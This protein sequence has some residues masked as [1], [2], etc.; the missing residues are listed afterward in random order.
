MPPPIRRDPNRLPPHD[1]TAHPPAIQSA[2]PMD[3]RTL[4][5]LEAAL[6]ATPANAPLLRVVLSALVDRGEAGRAARLLS[7][8]SQAALD[9]PGDRVLVGRI[10]V[11][12]GDWDRALAVLGTDSPDELLLRARVLLALDQHDEGRKAY[13]RAVAANPALEDPDLR[14]RLAAR[15]RAFIS[16]QAGTQPLLRV[17]ERGDDD[18]ATWL[19]PPEKAVTFADVGGLDELKEQ[20][21]RRII[22]PFQKPS[23]FQKFRKR[24]GGGLLLYGPPG[25]GKTLLARATA[26]ECR[27]KFFNVA[28]SDVLDMYVGES[29]AKL[30]AIFEKARASVPAVLFFDEVEALGG[31]RQYSREAAT[32]KLVSQFLAELDGFARNNQGVL[33]LGA[34]NVPWSLDTAF[35]RPGRFDRFLFVPPPDRP[36]REIILRL[37]LDGRPVDGDLGLDDLAKRTAGFSGADLMHV[38]ETA[39]DVAIA[40]TLERGDERP[41]TA[42][43]LRQALSEIKPTTTEWLTTARNYARYSNESGRYD[44]VLDFLA[45]HGTP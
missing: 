6:A 28:I 7:P 21:R 37:H 40:E 45:R 16:P 30:H 9:A 12:A 42:A 23:L 11:E 29:E 19:A 38:V 1:V 39:A 44:D 15:V 33:V 18:P 27:A 25:C 36:A 5:S 17:V 31:K 22:L 20:V 41:I 35:L 2:I 3:D 8:P 13:D 14:R 32:A 26:G 4:E 10:L 34:S 43:H 24:V